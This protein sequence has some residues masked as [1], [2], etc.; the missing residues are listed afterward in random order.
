M[1]AIC[2][3]SILGILAAQLVAANI[4]SL[5]AS[6]PALIS[7]P[8][9]SVAM[10]PVPPQN[11]REFVKGSEVIVIGRIS[12]F[13]KEGFEGPYSTTNVEDNRDVPK[14]PNKF[15]FSY[16]NLEIIE[17]IA[18]PRGIPLSSSISLRSGG[19]YSKRNEIAYDP[20]FY[21]VGDQK[22]YFLNMNPD[23]SFF[24]S[25]GA[26][27]ALNLDGDVVTFPDRAR[28]PIKFTD[29]TSRDTFIKT[30]KEESA[31]Q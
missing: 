22:L 10:M 19:L 13:T 6:T 28:T 3:L 25:F 9:Q 20:P 21:E 11:M 4:Q 27:G 26:W 30:V 16:F 29:M 2:T 5:I 15:P 24:T 23:G 14:P 1:V 17:V 18:N 31:K 8:L 12:R 7:Q